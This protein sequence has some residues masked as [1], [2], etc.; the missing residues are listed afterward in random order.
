MQYLNDQQFAI[1]FIENNVPEENYSATRAQIQC[2]FDSLPALG[3]QINR[4]RQAQPCRALHNLSSKMYA[5]YA[6]CLAP[7]DG[8]DLKDK[9]KTVSHSLCR[10]YSV[11][12]SQQPFRGSPENL[13]VREREYG[14]LIYTLQT[15]HLF[16]TTIAD[17]LLSRVL[18]NFSERDLEEGFRLLNDIIDRDNNY[19]L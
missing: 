13:S 6:N 10:W 7:T 1:L 18:V 5:G 3:E 17:N 12:E 14:M 2:E 8:D 11:I 19:V 15:D 9:L 16:L 4:N